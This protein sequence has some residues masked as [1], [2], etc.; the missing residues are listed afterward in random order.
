MADDSTP[1]EAFDLPA[2]AHER[3]MTVNGVRL[4][5]VEAGVSGPLVV[6]L[7]GFPE[8]WYSWRHQL[9]ELA[10]H[11][12]VLAPDLRG[13]NLSEKP[14][15]IQSYDLATLCDDIA[16]LIAASGE[17]QAD[18]VGH[19]WGGAIAWALAI[20]RPDV[21]RRL[22]ILN[23]PHPGAFARDLRHPAQLR[24]SWYIAFFQLPRLPEWTIARNDY[25]LLRASC[26]A[27]NRARRTEVFTQDDVERFVAAFARP[28]AATA[29]INYYR[30]LARGGQRAISPLRRIDAPT[31]VLW[32]ERD[33]ALGVELLDGLDRYVANLDVQRFSNAGHWLNQERPE[34]VTRALDAFLA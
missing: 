28:G 30:A 22:A 10:A 20:R 33:P 14:R 23:A 18:V 11:R 19:D 7:H 6:L 4:H 26:A 9:P 32:G 8:F 25:A 24:R 15:G 2:G 31:L 21:V 12:R 17:R 27:V 3:A 16:A 13:Y 5:V 34:D 29:A 1:R